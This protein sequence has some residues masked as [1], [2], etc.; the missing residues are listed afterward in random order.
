MKPT[1]VLKIVLPILAILYSTFQS[2]SQTT[3]IAAGSSWKYLDNGTDQGTAWRGVGFNDAAWASGNSELGYGDGGEATTINAGCT[4]VST[5]NTKFITSYFRK[6]INVTSLSSFGSFTFNIV[7]DDGVVVYVNGIEVLRDNMP[8]GSINYNT[9]ASTAIAAPGESTFYPF[10]ISPC[11]FIEGVNTIAVEIHQNAASS[12]DVSFNLSLVGSPLGGVP[13]LTRGPYLQMPNETAIT[14]RWRTSVACYGRVEVGPSNGSYTTAIVDETCPT[15]EHVVRVT[16]LATDTKYFYRISSTTGTIFQGAADNFFRTLPPATTTRKIRIAAFGDCGR[17]NATYQDENL[18][19]YRNYLTAN[20]I[21][22]PD[23]WILMGDNA[24]NSGTDAEYTTNFFGIYGPTLLKNHNL[25]PSPGNHDYGNNSA[26]KPSRSMPYHTIFSVPQNG[27]SGGVGSTKSNFYSYDVGNIHFLS[28]DSYGTETDATHMGT[29]G[30]SALKTWL[31]ADLAANTK[32]WI[33]AYWHHPPY[34]KTSHNSDSESDLVAIRQNF[35]GYL[36]SKG[37]DMIINGHSHGYE[38]SYLLKNF[39]GN[40]NTFTLGTHSVGSSIGTYTSNST[41]PYVYNSTPSNHGTVYVVAGS[42]GASGG[43]QADFDA[44]AFPNSVNDAGIFYFEVEDNRLDAK[45]LRRNGTVF[46]QFTIMKDVNKTQ[47]Y[48]ILNGNSI[49]LTASWPSATNYAWSNASTT[50]SI[51][52]TPPVGSNNYTVTDNFGCVTDNITV[53]VFGVLPVKLEKYAVYLNR[54]KVSVDWTTSSET[55]SKHFTVERSVDGLHFEKLQTVTGAGNSTSP[56]SY[57]VT[58]HTPLKGIS[59]YR[60]TQTDAED[61]IRLF[62]VKKISNTT[63]KLFDAKLS[64][65]SGTLTVSTLSAQNSKMIV[66]VIDMNGRIV[67][68]EIWKLSMGFNQGKIRLSRGSYII[69]FTTEND[70]LHVQ[71]IVV[72]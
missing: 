64:V 3:F 70:E 41:C 68:T 21:D 25:F 29:N 69:S 17:S 24:Y 52:I 38:R 5:C 49:T 56:K 60:L 51:T 53:N 7:R 54:E 35:I 20:G 15:T 59:Y 55:L 48:N 2:F 65:S 31:D 50:R 23:A 63:G 61:N 16:G 66:R 44:Y 6:T 58:D 18:T 32:K 40:W 71:K 1:I 10:T 34:T 14:I 37:V 33:I 28:L 47:T 43:V 67:T 57:S 39:T 45:M 13:A 22:A 42:A 4:P 27:E 72:E 12:S 30:S 11:Y 19:N 62:D 26:N 36:E 9:L 8:G 46:D